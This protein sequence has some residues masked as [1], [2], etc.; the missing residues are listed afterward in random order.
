MGVHKTKEKMQ[1]LL[2]LTL[3]AI[4]LVSCSSRPVIEYNGPVTPEGVKPVLEALDRSD[5]Y[6][7]RI[8][9][10]G[11][12][13]AAGLALAEKVQARK[14]PV[15]IYEYCG[16]A[17]ALIFIASPMR[18]VEP[19]TALLFHWS[20]NSHADFLSKRLGK[21][22]LEA[23]KARQLARREL[24]ILESAGIS[25]A[26][27][28]DSIKLVEPTCVTAYI[29]DGKLNYFG[30]SKLG[31]VIFSGK[32]LKQYGFE[33]RINEN[34]IHTASGLESIASKHP[35]WGPVGF[36]P[37]R[38]VANRTKLSQSVNE[39]APEDKKAQ[40]A[41]EKTGLSDPIQPSRH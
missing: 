36:V 40:Q 6:S 23:E 3:G 33:E 32:A 1:G 9:S 26:L 17:C 24:Q 15:A 37:S 39:C 27:L 38:E 5:R 13:G 14:I 4:V 30:R 21:K 22:N 8:R 19:N 11:G 41:I 20:L 10:L 16:S 34:L 12:D 31:Y 7:L 18:R 2:M 35:E 28:E 29:Q 25:R